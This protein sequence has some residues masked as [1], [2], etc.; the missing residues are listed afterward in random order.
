MKKLFILLFFSLLSPIVFAQWNLLNQVPTSKDLY[1][2]CFAEANTV[3]AAGT[4]GT[5]LK[6]TDAGN[7]WSVLSTGTNN[8]Y[9]ESIYFMNADTGIVV[10]ANQGGGIVLKTIDG[11][12]TWSIR[13]NSTGSGYFSVHFAD[14]NNGFV[15]GSWL[16]GA[17]GLI[18][19]TTDGGDTWGEIYPS[20]NCLYS[21]F[22]LDSLTGYAVGEIGTILKTV[23][24]GINWTS[25]NPTF[26]YLYDVYFSSYTTGYIA[27]SGTILK[28]T[29]SGA[30][31]SALPAVKSGDLVSVFFTSENNGYVV[32][33]GGTILMTNNAGT[34]W[35]LSNS[36]TD[37]DLHSVFF[38][39]ENTG[40]A[41]GEGGTILQTANAGALT[42]NEKEIS[43]FNFYP[44]PATNKIVIAFSNLF[45]D[46][47]TVSISTISNEQLFQKTF[48]RQ[49]MIEMDVNTFTNGI[50]LLKIQ[51]KEGV[52]IR[53]LLIQ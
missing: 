26:S 20:D 7:S 24:G 21:T 42:I 17:K 13:K 23:D 45:P 30:T 50:Y 38:T 3:Y 32:G 52:E 8:M 25:S 34:N 15:A 6:T 47:I 43:K 29:D 49:N 19:K 35:K 12:A 39:D 48:F 11:G 46:E 53:K 31:W 2:I 4:V 18:L 51:T 41:A 10:G 40:Y 1:S 44:N 36:G 28:T 22:F 5:L 33:S 9:L 27:G 16:D 14:A 37:K